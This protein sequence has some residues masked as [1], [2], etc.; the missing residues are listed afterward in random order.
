MPIPSIT[1]GEAMKLSR[2]EIQVLLKDWYLAWEKHDLDKVMPFFHE[3][4]FFENW[5]GAY[6]KGR[7]ALREA[8]TPWFQNHGDFRFLE[9]ETFIDEKLQKALYRWILEWPSTEPGHE[10]KLEIR[11]GVDVLHFKDGK[12]INKLTYTKTAIEIDN[13][14]YFLHL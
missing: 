14:R 8:W 9:A 4:V 5:T 10:D 13:K 1:G 6:V 2:K 11:K 3:D 12:I 7:E